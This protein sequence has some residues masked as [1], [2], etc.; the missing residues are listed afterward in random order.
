MKNLA[1]LLFG[2]LFLF[3]CEEESALP[4]TTPPPTV[5]YENVVD[6]VVLEYQLDESSYLSNTGDVNRKLRIQVTKEGYYD[7]YNISNLVQSSYNISLLDSFPTKHKVSL[8]FTEPLRKV[9]VQLYNDPTT[10]LETYQKVSLTSYKDGVILNKDS[11]LNTSSPAY[12]LSL[13]SGQ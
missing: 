3:S 5:V 1:L 7:E 13:T 12:I 9:F 11:V 6:S 2:I 8:T 10:Q 4:P